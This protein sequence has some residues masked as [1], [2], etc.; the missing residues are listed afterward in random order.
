MRFS[1]RKKTILLIVSIGL[2]IGVIAVLIYGRGIHDLVRTQYANQSIDIANTVAVEL[3]SDCVER[4]RK[5][6]CDIYENADH[7]VL[8]DQWGTPAFEDYISLFS[9]IEKSEDYLVLR[10]HLRRIQDVNRVDCLYITWLDVENECLVYLVDGAY[11]D[12]CPPGCVDPIYGDFSETLKHPELGFAPNITNTPEYGWIVAT[13]MPI[14]DEEGTV[15]AYAAVD[16]SMNDIMNAEHRFLLI[17]SGILFAV[18]VLVCIFGIWLVTRF[19]VRPINAL[20]QAAM[21]YTA[22]SHRFSELNIK[23]GDEIGV[24]ADS[25][26]RMEQDID[27]YIENLT[28]TRDELV[29]AREHAERMDLAAN[30]DALTK[31]RNKRA[32]DVD[33]I[34][35]NVGKTDYALVM[36]DLNDLKIIN[37]TYGHEKGNNSI[38]ALCQVICR[39]FR[40]SVVYRLGGDEFLVILENDDFQ[41]REALV[42]QFQEEI[43]KTSE[44]ETLPPWERISAAIGCAEY[45]PEKDG[46]ID[47]VFNRAD[48]KMY[49][50]KKRM[51]QNIQ[52]RKERK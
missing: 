8:S 6:V 38:K 11:E 51:K 52:E 5:A 39:I 35:F 40:Y 27:G 16:M 1:L 29:S 12:P 46:N 37:D 50:N 28:K 21:Q 2:L 31:V 10:D 48:K 25:M 44:D 42:A 23:H 14:F 15:L 19:I 30:I 3:E 17:V 7:V 9:D 47:A 41:D 20:S 36:I 22:A 33:A 49:E 43:R 4:L 24:L 13:D 45:D 18:T 26:V 32:Y 34:R